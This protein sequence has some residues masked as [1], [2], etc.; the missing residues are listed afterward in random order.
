MFIPI[1][2][3][4]IQG[5]NHLGSYAFAEPESVSYRKLKHIVQNEKNGH[6]NPNNSQNS[7][8]ENHYE[9]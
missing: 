1:F 2:K 9:I 4:N 5:Q 7:H 6:K 8:D 3:E